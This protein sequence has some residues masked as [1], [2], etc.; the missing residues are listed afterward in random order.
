MKRQT[1][2]FC[3]HK[4]GVAS[5]KYFGSPSQQQPGSGSAG[6]LTVHWMEDR[7]GYLGIRAHLNH[8][9]LVR[10]SQCWLPFIFDD[11]TLALPDLSTRSQ[12]HL[13]MQHSFIHT[14]MLMSKYLKLTGGWL[15]P[16]N[17]EPWPPW[18]WAMPVYLVKSQSVS[19]LVTRAGQLCRPG[20][21]PAPLLPRRQPSCWPQTWS[22][23][24][25]MGIKLHIFLQNLHR[26]VVWSLKPSVSE[27]LLDKCPNFWA[28]TTCLNAYLN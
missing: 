18:S 28:E 25:M 16:Q 19:I 17:I 6:Q 26:P 15:L 13:P 23:C 8:N 20:T 22:P 14:F 11:E 2:I 27:D 10:R 12:S 5:F 9:T 21:S 3:Q 1:E 7:G 4:H 24:L